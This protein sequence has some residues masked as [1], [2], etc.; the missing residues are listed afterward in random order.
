MKKFKKNITGKSNK[1]K[2]VKEIKIKPVKDIKI[3]PIKPV[4]KKTKDEIEYE[5]YF[6]DGDEDEIENGH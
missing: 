3:K 2:P 4:V 1:I 6:G 5:K